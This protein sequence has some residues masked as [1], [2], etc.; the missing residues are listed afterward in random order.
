MAFISYIRGGTINN[1]LRERETLSTNFYGL[2]ASTYLH[3]DG[4]LLIAATGRTYTNPTQRAVLGTII[5][6]DDNFGSSSL[7]T[8]AYGSLGASTNDMGSLSLAVLND[9]KALIAARH[10]N[11]GIHIP[12]TL[13]NGGTV[14]QLDA[15]PLDI[16]NSVNNSIT[17]GAGYWRGL[18]RDDNTL[19]SSLLTYSPQTIDGNLYRYKNLSAWKRSAGG[20]WSGNNAFTNYLYSNYANDDLMKVRTKGNDLLVASERR[21]SHTSDQISLEVCRVSDDIYQAPSFTRT[22]PIDRTVTV[23]ASPQFEAALAATYFDLAVSDNGQHAILAYAEKFGTGWRL[24]AFKLVIVDGADTWEELTVSPTLLDGAPGQGLSV[25]VN[26]SGAAQIYCQARTFS[27]YGSSTYYHYRRVY[28]KPTGSNTFTLLD[29]LGSPFNGP[30]SSGS[31]P[32]DAKARLMGLGNN[33]TGI[34][35]FNGQGTIGG[36]YDWPFFAYTVG[37][38]GLVGGP[39]E[40][41]EQNEVSDLRYVLP[42]GRN[43][44][45]VD[46]SKNEAHIVYTTLRQYTNGNYYYELNRRIF[47]LT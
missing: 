18:L 2:S 29:Y 20:T 7:T 32:Y 45:I 39:Y 24:K 13:T 40:L 14:S 37:I 19:I 12:Y 44:T 25:A 1:P 47:D 35:I 8:L 27:G 31:N 21:T 30:I 10:I 41:E 11:G 28:S 3:P 33:G 22:G 42:N 34:Y 4:R 9:D 17:G 16:Q 36:G 43:N 38:D 6:S 5:T 15:L 23:Y 26:D 46:S